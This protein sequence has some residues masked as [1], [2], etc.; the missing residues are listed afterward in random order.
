MWSR[1]ASASCSDQRQGSLPASHCVPQASPCHQPCRLSRNTDCEIRTCSATRRRGTNC[2]AL[3]ITCGEV[4]YRE[5]R[6]A[7]PG[8]LLAVAQK[9]IVAQIEA[10]GPL[11]RNVEW[12]HHGAVSGIDSKWRSNL[13]EGRHVG[14]VQPGGF[15][16]DSACCSTGAKQSQA[17]TRLWL[18]AITA[19]APP[20]PRDRG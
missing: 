5:A 10:I 2:R 4:L 20:P 9:R 19:P 18:A 1:M 17:A 6:L 14:T 11:P 13:P 8:I 12:L 3:S 16:R 15:A 7:A